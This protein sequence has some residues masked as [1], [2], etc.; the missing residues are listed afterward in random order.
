MSADV[1]TTWGVLLDVDGIADGGRQAS[2]SVW[3]AE[4]RAAFFDRCPRLATFLR[5]EDAELRPTAEHLEPVDRASCARGI[6]IGVSVVEVRPTSFTMAVRIRSAG[7]DAG[8]AANGRCTV[9][10]QRRA[11]L[12]AEEFLI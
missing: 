4:G 1:L 6:R 3:F 7:S 10:I 9:L 11:I 2:A 12:V 8:R 5:A